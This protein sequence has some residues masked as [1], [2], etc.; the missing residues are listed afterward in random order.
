M[1]HAYGCDVKLKKSN[2]LE[3]MPVGGRQK[4]KSFTSRHFTFLLG[5]AFIGSLKCSLCLE[6][7]LDSKELT[8]IGTFQETFFKITN[9]VEAIKLSIK[10]IL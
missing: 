5:S 4:G 1:G 3:K 2:R 6:S 9:S 10:F 8:N 7:I